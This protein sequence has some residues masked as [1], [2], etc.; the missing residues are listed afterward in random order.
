MAHSSFPT[1]ARAI[2]Q[3]GPRRLVVLWAQ[4]HLLS[5]WACIILGIA[6]WPVVV[7]GTGEGGLLEI[8]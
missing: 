7:S 1:P 6:A 4:A 2:S 8:L 5:A 3:V